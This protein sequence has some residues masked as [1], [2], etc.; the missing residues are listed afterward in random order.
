MDNF[1]GFLCFVL[2]ILVVVAWIT[3][4]VVSIVAKVWLFMIVGAVIFPVA[5]IH[6]IATWLGFVW[7]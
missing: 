6:G 3:H 4:I 7:V 1:F 2:Y 5:I